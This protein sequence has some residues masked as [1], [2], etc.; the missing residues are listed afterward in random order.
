MKLK[1][2]SAEW[3]GSAEA[4]SRGD[5][6]CPRLLFPCVPLVLGRSLLLWVFACV[7][8]VT[9]R[10][11]KHNCFPS[12]PLSSKTKWDESAAQAYNLVFRRKK[13]IIWTPW[14]TTHG[15]GPS[16]A[17]VC[18]PIASTEAE[19]RMNPASVQPEP[20]QIR[21][22]CWGIVHTLHKFLGLSFLN[23]TIRELISVD[24][25]ST[26]HLPSGCT[27]NSRVRLAKKWEH[28]KENTWALKPTLQKTLEDR[29][30]FH[31]HRLA[32]F[33][34]WTRHTT[35]AIFRFSVLFIKTPM[36]FIIE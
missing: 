3:G 18:D 8:S 4:Y 29:K 23:F 19:K 16:W 33:I 2:E 36:T 15:L 31:V 1:S 35:K 32:E 6:L 9:L 17:L 10:L 14:T 12:V 24:L 20:T 28:C 27:Q 13:S 25:R 34:L 22:C 7:Y 30:T 11:I 26:K 5:G 21:F